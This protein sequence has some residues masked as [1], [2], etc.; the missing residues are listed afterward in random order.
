L[1]DFEQLSTDSTDFNSLIDMM[2]LQMNQLS[3]QDW[4]Y[5]EKLM[6][7]FSE[8]LPVPGGSKDK[9]GSKRPKTDI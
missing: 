8:K 4:G 2:Q 5:L 6:Q 3:Q 7:D 9:K 1:K